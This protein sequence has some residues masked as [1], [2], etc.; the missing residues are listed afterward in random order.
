M[1]KES[2]SGDE[3]PPAR[4]VVLAY[5]SVVLQA[6]VTVRKFF[7]PIEAQIHANELAAHDIEYALLNQNAPGA[8]GWYSGFAQVQ[9]QVR[10]ED[11]AIA[12][13]LLSRL[14]IEPGEVEPADE[15][16]PQAPIPDPGGQGVLVSTAAYEDPRQ[17]YDAAGLLG[18][19]H[20]ECFL[21]VLIPR[22][23]LPR[24]MGARFVVRVRE[25]DLERAQKVLSAEDDADQEDEPRCPRCGSWQ[26]YLL[27]AP[28]PGLWNFITGRAGRRSRQIECLQ[29]HHRWNADMGL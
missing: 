27:P 18:A 8:L 19:S 6:P 1:S 13:E 14:R 2:S 11:A 10:E 3:A 15:S 12:N 7:D 26:T 4:P 21:P 23:D 17:L 25:G 16:D 9:L 28:W 20:I 5:Q 22:G 24:G 29:C